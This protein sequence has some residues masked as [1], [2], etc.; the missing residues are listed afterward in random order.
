W[1]SDG[2]IPGGAGRPGRHPD[3]N[4][5]AVQPDVGEGRPNLMAERQPEE[6]QTQTQQEGHGHTFRSAP[7][8]G[9]REKSGGATSQRSAGARSAST[10][11]LW[12][13]PESGGPRRSYLVLSGNLRRGTGPGRR[14]CEH[15]GYYGGHGAGSSI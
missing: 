11:S 13:C 14:S 9:E 8:V 2:A 5:E 7:L 4:A 15:W 1:G 12:S 10:G 3:A 6:D